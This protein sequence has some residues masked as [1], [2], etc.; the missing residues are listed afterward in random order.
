M[1]SLIYIGLYAQAGRQS[2]NL[3]PL[4][5]KTVEPVRRQIRLEDPCPNFHPE[6]L[7]DKPKVLIES[8]RV[9]R[10]GCARRHKVVGVPPA[11]RWRCLAHS[12]CCCVPQDRA[13]TLP[14]DSSTTPC[15]VLCSATSVW[16]GYDTDLR[17][18]GSTRTCARFKMSAFKIHL[19][20]I[21]ESLQSILVSIYASMLLRLCR[22]SK[23]LDVPV[24]PSLPPAIYSGPA[25][26]KA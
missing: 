14:Y 16:H 6:P 13:S 20:P 18:S 2:G 5:A 4:R 7:S 3:V 15:P 25:R 26:L 8:R 19:Y 11:V 23:L 12:C 17:A 22:Y 24:G 9:S 1:V 10:C 21:L